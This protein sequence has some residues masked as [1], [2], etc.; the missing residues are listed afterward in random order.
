MP[1]DLSATL[2]TH[3]G[4]SSFRPGQEEALR[5]LLGGRHAVVV[6]PTGAGKS[7][8]YQLAA[9]RRG[10]L[11][12]VVSP[13]I[14]LMEDQ[15]RSLAR[16]GIAAACLHSPV[17]PAEQTRR[18]RAM[19]QGAYRLV[20]VAPER[21]RSVAFRSVLAGLSV[22]LV[23]VDEAHCLSQWGHDFRPDYLHIAAAREALGSPLTVALTAT[24]TPRVQE[25]VEHLLH[26][27]AAARI[28][29][30]FNRPNLTFE[31]RYAAEPAVKAAACAGLQVVG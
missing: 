8:I 21:L 19:A 7:L 18:L 24:A 10:D 23:A 17:E 30:G 26:L 3:F 28:V 2:R 9:L 29:T 1:A 4:F 25:E 22:G 31:V 6:M 20:Y 13:L 5:A 27:R 11:C 12:L 16:R 14:A 15:V